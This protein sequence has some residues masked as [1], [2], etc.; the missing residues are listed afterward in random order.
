MC[1]SCVS[2]AQVGVRERVVFYNTENLFDTRNDTLT[3]DDDFT[4][5]GKQ[6]WNRE[7]YIR[8]LLNISKVLNGL[9]AGKF[10]L[11]IGLS[12]VENR[13]VLSDLVNKTVL[14]DGNYG[15]VHADSPDTRGIDVALLYRKD[16]FRLLHNAF[17]PVHLKSGETTR[18]ILYCEGIF[19]RN[20]TL[21]VFVCHFPSMRGG[22]AKSEWKRIKAASVVRQKL[23][24]IQNIHSLAMVLIMG[25]LNG[26]ANTPAQK[27]LKIQNPESGIIES[28]NFYNTGYYLLGKPYGSYRYKGEWQ[29]LDHIIVSGNLLNGKVDLQ[30]SR[31]MGIYDA[32]FLFEEERGA[33]GVR[34]KPTY[35]GPRYIGGY[36]DHL[37]VFIDLK[38]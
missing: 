25:D 9:G 38:K 35:R 29:T 21:H 18:D 5:R 36:S 26:R 37:P 13:N 3:V 22:E 12:E 11:L 17:F 19:G 20:D 6:H 14:A 16:S 28:E 8:K 31:R 30:A 1:V 27:T 34:P 33:F 32:D 4:P 24:S 2:Y 23:D 7:R 10:P 15:I